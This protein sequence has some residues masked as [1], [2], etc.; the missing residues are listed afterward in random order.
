MARKTMR[1]SKRKVKKTRRMRGGQHGPNGSNFAYSLKDRNAAIAAREAREAARTPEQVAANEKREMEMNEE[2]RRENIARKSTPEYI[3]AVKAS[4][5]R[6][7]MIRTEYEKLL[8][9]KKTKRA[10]NI[11]KYKN[12]PLL[13]ARFGPKE[14]TEDE[15]TENI[16]NVLEKK[17]PQTKYPEIYRATIDRVIRMARGSFY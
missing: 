16:A 2:A 4:N 17:Y 9:E 8:S 10:S 13:P 14:L 3:A 1:K 15:E 11:K 6:D 5:E 7:D 12:N